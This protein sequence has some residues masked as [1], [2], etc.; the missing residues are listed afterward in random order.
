MAY[1][2]MH[3]VRIL[4]FYLVMPYLLVVTAEVCLHWT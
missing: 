1:I 2:H 4:L 3:F